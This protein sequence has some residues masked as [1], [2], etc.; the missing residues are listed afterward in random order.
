MDWKVKEGYFL[1]LCTSLTVCLI[2]SENADILVDRP[3]PVRV[4]ESITLTCTWQKQ[5]QKVSQITW[6]KMINYKSVDL[7]TYTKVMGA[8]IPKDY[9]DVLNIS[10]P[11]LS[12]TAI[13]IWK[14]RIKDEGHYRCKFSAFPAG[15][16]WGEI[17]VSVYE[18]VKGYL[19]KYNESA[20]SITAECVTSG[21]PPAEI[22]WFGAGTGNQNGSRLETS[23]DTAT[24]THWIIVK[25]TRKRQIAEQLECR[26]QHRGEESTYKMPKEIP[27][28]LVENPQPV[29]V[30]QKVTLQCTLQK[31]NAKAS[32]IT[33]QKIVSGKAA[34]LGTYTNVM[35]VYIHDKYK[36]VLDITKLGLNKTAI[37]IWKAGIKDEGNYRCVFNV[38]GTGLITGDIAVSVFEPVKV[39]IKKHNES[40]DSVTGLCVAT[41]WPPAEISW[42]GVGTGNPNGS[43]L[44][45]TNET[46]TLAHWIILDKKSNSHIKLDEKLECRVHHLG[47]YSTFKLEHPAT[48]LTPAII[49]LIIGLI[50]V[51]F[52]AL[53]AV[54]CRKK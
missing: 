47:N 43:H 37:T 52:G 34:D 29:R 5:G 42:S 35:G 8:F 38:F 25:T 54:C 22:S 53:A 10:S 21:W 14:A 32:Q 46:A 11:S 20:D 23:D 40:M 49:I 3:Q 33:W 30:G 39:Y 45:T 16:V 51:L 4:G 44:E 50:L 19:K 18:P 9:M 17:A 36:N 15:L 48:G 31:K 28:V 24:L 13:T 12:K 6:Q 27:D 1:F 7:G 41:G 2:T 26:V